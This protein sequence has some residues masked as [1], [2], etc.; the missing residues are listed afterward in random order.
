MWSLERLGRVRLSRH[1]YMRDFLYSEIAGF[2]GLQNFPSDPALAIE[3]GSQLCQTILDPLHETFG[4]IRIRSSYRAPEVNGMGN[5]NG[6]NCA[7]NEYA[8]ARHIWD[9]R[10]A[11]GC[12]G[13]VACVIIPWFSDQ[14]AQGRDW[15]DL[16]WWLHDHVPYSEIVFFSNLAAFNIYWRE[17]PRGRIAGWIGGNSVLKRAGQPAGADPEERQRRYADFPPF[18]GIK[19]PALPGQ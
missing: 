17:V 8:R 15:R 7:S 13:A 5:Q 10:D 2:Y 9:Q 3:T 18:R 12:A 14:F 4:N 11:E 16:A 6:L 19:F 1:F